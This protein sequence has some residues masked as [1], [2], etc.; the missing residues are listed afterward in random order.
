MTSTKATGSRAGAIARARKYIEDGTFE[1]DLAR[2]VAYK[3]E[4]QK[5]PESLP[6]LHRYLEEEMAPAFERLG[7]TTRIYDNPLPGQ[8][9]VLLATR[10]EDERL[11]TVLGYG[12]GD[13]IRGLE[14]QWTKGDGPWI[15]ARDGDRLYGRGTSDNKGQHTLNMA[16]LEAA[17]SE[18]G[19]RLGFNV[20]F[21]IETGEEAGSKG[22]AELVA[23]HKADFAADVLIASDGPRVKPER[24]TMTLGCRGAINFDLVCDLRA[25][26]HHSGNWGGL[27]ANP[28]IV[29]ANALA[30]IVGPRGELLVAAL[31]APAMS[32]SVKAAL[33]DIEV[34][35]GE[36]GPQVDAWWGE[37]DLSPAERVYGANVFNVLAFTTG[38][39]GR[40]VN[41][42]P[43]NAV[44]N[45]QL[46]FVAGTDVEGV[47]PAL[48][49]H[50][51]EIGFPVKV[52]PPPA[53]ND[54]RFAATRTEPD[55]PW[56]VFAARSLQRSVN[57]KPAVV[58]QMG[59]SICN[60]VFTD[61]LGIPTLWIPHSYASCLQ[62]APDEHMLMS[63]AR[64]AIELMAG[65]Y[66]DIGGDGCPPKSAGRLADV[67]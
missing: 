51:D 33:A 21:I 36:S 48:Q 61:I 44:A 58:P 28:G 9:P 18:R 17:Q 49:R 16:A 29:L 20:K 10:I 67:H 13:V 34:G 4:S 23:A 31:K 46:R 14:D 45:C 60:D 3:T 24:P 7:C 54:G 15:T 39:P 47:M 62:H 1:A 22:L 25:A 30:S 41:A 2:R 53:V 59:G 37:P 35:G 52:M 50:L 66:W 26:G 32:A 65:L 40:P 56:A 55:H 57:V 5:L 42:I 27:I 11:A 12:H 8:G 64:S 6:E 19:G 63:S 38:T 43:P